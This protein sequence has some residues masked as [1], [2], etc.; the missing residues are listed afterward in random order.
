MNSLHFFVSIL[1]FPDPVPIFIHNE[2]QLNVF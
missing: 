1:T 2:I